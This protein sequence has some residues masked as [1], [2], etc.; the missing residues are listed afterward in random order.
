MSILVYT[1]NW[2]GKFK[3]SSFELVSFASELG[4]QMNQTVTAVSIGNI[5]N[6]ELQK[7]G[8]YGAEKIISAADSK[9][10][11]LNNQAYSATIAQAAQKEN[12]SV[13]IFANN[14]TGKALAPA[15]SIKLKAGIVSGVAGL[16]VSI[17]PFVVHKKMFTGKAFGNVQINSAVKILTLAQNSFQIVENPCE[18]AIEN[19]SPELKDSWFVNQVKDTQ[20][21]SGT[22]LLTDAEIVVSGGR[23]MKSADNWGPLEALATELGAAT[24]CSRPVAD[25]GW[26]PHAEH[27]GQT[28]KIVA[29]NLYFACGISGAIQHVAGISSS[30]FIVAINKD[31]DAP[32]FE[33]ANYGIIGDVQKVLPDLLNQIKAFKAGV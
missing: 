30:K 16:P 1:Q 5:G 11:Q 23:G 17:E 13:V 27:V 18:L 9:L 3:K 25:E 19:F 31:P 14:F 20:K 22:I 24:A 15:L 7:L 2:D 32:I 10:N 26:R 28:G 21:S 6:D 12:A 8:K 4:K 29:P 33:T